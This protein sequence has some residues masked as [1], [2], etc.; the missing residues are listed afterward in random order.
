MAASPRRTASFL[1][2]P[3][4]KKTRGKGRLQL[5][6]AGLGQARGQREAFIAV[7]TA[8]TWTE[9]EGGV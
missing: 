3:Q 7:L 5:A 6:W 9:E 2:N 1:I 4:K 8:R